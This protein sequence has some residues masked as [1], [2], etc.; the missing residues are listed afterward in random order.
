[1]AN[2]KS[3]PGKDGKTAQGKRPYATLD[4]KA[5][6]IKTE[7]KPAEKTPGPAPAAAYATANTG[8]G[9]AG[10][11]AKVKADAA[12]ASASSAQASASAAQKNPGPGD[13]PSA[14]RPRPPEASPAAPA[15]SSGSFI[16]H[17]AAGIVGGVLT[18]TGAQWALPQLGVDGSVSRL[19]GDNAALAKRLDAVEKTAATSA[20]AAPQVDVDGLEKRIAEVEK[21]AGQ[22]PVLSE[23][24]KQLVADTKAAL[25]G[26]ASDAG[27]P[28][29]ITRLGK[30]ENQM[31]ALTN[32]GANDPN[33]GR[34]EQ[35][36]ALIG[37]VSDLETSLATQ[38]SALRQNVAAD[39]EA[40]LVSATAASEAAK[41]GTQRIDRDVAGI[42]SDI[43]NIDQRLQSLQSERDRLAAALDVTKSDTERLRG[44]VEH[45][46]QD[47]AKPADVSAAVAPVAEKISSL[48]AGV[49]RVMQAESDRRLSA[50][51]VVLALQLQNLK[52]ALDRGQGFAAELAAVKKAAG[53]AFDFTALE[54]LQ[55]TGVPSVAELTA[56]FREGAN[57]AIDADSEA[58]D[59]TV[60]DRL[61]AGAKSVVRVRK[62]NH[63]PDD[64]STEAVIGRMET[65]LNDGRFE[66]V[67]Q[68]AKDLSPKAQDASRSL[69]DK[70]AARAS[71][72]AAIAKLEDQ[73]KASLVSGTPGKDPNSAP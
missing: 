58:E 13:A 62:I 32:A 34:V 70:I 38:L 44:T 15:K 1:M 56:A 10:D 41:S 4:L 68:E 48:E 27:T 45:L 33:A 60:V 21:A 61:L 23:N 69:L 20:A 3:N 11:G 59:A 46:K 14:A 25:A 9:A 17:L 19:E 36:A 18:L 8:S 47:T 7:P 67:L 57:R 30:I 12:A 54:K 42:K 55:D 40:R 37:K 72:D 6:E 65:A 53:P 51:R 49:E 63:E 16:S 2:D 39:V 26:A 64:K 73:L 71:I 22:I 50:E 28:E 5:T 52:R 29:L 35:L 24:Q 43:A 31:Q 66:A